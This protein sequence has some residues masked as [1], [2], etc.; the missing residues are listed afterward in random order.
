MESATATQIVTRFAEAAG[1]TTVVC[2]IVGHVLLLTTGVP[3]TYPPLRPLQ[4]VSG[5]V[6]GAFLVAVGYA[7][8]AAVV[9]DRRTLVLLFVAGGVILLIASFYL[10]Y[11]LSFT[12]SIRFAGVTVAAQL[13]QCLLHTLVVGMSVAVFLR[14]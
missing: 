6:G 13:G 3:P 11:R 12:K 2:L 4:I 1:L 9:R 10:P 7:L 8:L 5:T 14:R